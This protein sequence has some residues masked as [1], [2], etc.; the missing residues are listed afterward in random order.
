MRIIR[1]L[2]DTQGKGIMFRNN[3]HLQVVAYIDADWAG[4]MID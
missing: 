3:S 4:Y 1:Y 2:K